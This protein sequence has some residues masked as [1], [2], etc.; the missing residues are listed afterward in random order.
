[1]ELQSVTLREGRRAVI[2]NFE[3]GFIADLL[4]K[5]GGNITR[6][7][8]EARKERRAFGRLVKKYNLEPGRL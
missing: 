4:R 7:A 6:A 8:A 3:R 5:H 2:E 1:S